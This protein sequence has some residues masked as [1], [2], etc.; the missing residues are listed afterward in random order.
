MIAFVCGML[1]LPLVIGAAA[2]LYV[3]RWGDDL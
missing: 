3:A 1:I 2:L